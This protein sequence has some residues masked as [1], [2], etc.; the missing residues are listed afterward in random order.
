VV[1]VSDCVFCEII[2]KTSPAEI[3]GEW[4]EAVAFVPLNPVTEG[5]VLV[6]P[7]LHVR[8]A[9]SYPDLTALVMKR[10]AMIASAPCNII[11][12]VG[13]LATQ[14]VFHLHVHIVPRRENDKLPLPWTSQLALES[15]MADRITELE[16]QLEESQL[17]SIEARN[18]GID[19]DEVREHFRHKIRSDADSKWLVQP[20]R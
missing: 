16:G 1:P 20:W 12:S 2:A 13:A 15:I 8:D 10:V 9:V 4:D 7:R 6:V 3:V 14:T 11:T 18:P 5:H 19:M 17:R